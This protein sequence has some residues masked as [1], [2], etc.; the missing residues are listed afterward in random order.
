MSDSLDII[1]L[2]LSRLSTC[3]RCVFVLLFAQM[4]TAL[5]PTVTA[6]S[7]PTSEISPVWMKN[8]RS[9]TLIQSMCISV[10][11][12][13]VSYNPR[14][15]GRRGT[16]TLSLSRIRLSRFSLPAVVLR[17]E[18]YLCVFALWFTLDN[19]DTP[20]RVCIAV[21]QIWYQTSVVGFQQEYHPKFI[22]SVLR[23]L[24]FFKE[25]CRLAQSSWDDITELV[26]IE[27]HYNWHNSVLS[28]AASFER[29]TDTGFSGPWSSKLACKM[30]WKEWVMLIC[31]D[32]A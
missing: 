11:F 10:F 15:S 20:Q 6:S 1:L 7:E 26:P 25:G 8:W 27:F 30:K 28:G 16:L 29:P 18:A 17:T 12:C 5:T 3:L 13:S 4:P 2:C 9:S 24:T 22:F 21:M 32:S 14:C 31:F 23:T 19:R